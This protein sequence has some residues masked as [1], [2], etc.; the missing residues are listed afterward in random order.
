VALDALSNIDVQQD[1]LIIG[2]GLHL[3][4]GLLVLLTRRQ[5]AAVATGERWWGVWLEERLT[6]GLLAGYWTVVAAQVWVIA[7]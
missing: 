6:V 1:R 2:V 4:V 3:C 7:R 5:I